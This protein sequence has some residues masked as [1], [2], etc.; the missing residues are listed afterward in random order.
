M[1]ILLDDLT[2]P[3]VRALLQ[4]HLDDM[5]EHSPEGSSYALDLSELQAVDIS[6]WVAWDGVEVAGCCALKELSPTSGEIKSMRTHAAHLRKGVAARMLEYLLKV[7]K[8]RG[9]SSLS[10]E[11]GTGPIFDPALKLYK[12]YGFESGEA[13]SNYKPGPFNQ[14]LHISL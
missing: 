1:E 10:L 14:F 13:F 2:H 9:Y 4:T 11:T 8:S 5:H 7:A 6:F 3:D 12:K